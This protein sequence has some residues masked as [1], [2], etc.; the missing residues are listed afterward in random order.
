MAKDGT[1]SRISSRG[2]ETQSSLS[3]VSV[4]ESVTREYGCT[5]SCQK[6]LEI[7]ASYVLLRDPFPERFKEYARELAKFEE[8]GV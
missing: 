1:A 3:P 6:R 5:W 8:K 2:D 4:M 7:L